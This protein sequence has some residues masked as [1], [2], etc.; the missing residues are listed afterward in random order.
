MLEIDSFLSTDFLINIV[1]FI[2]LSI[3]CANQ[4]YIINLQTKKLDTTKSKANLKETSKYEWMLHD[5]RR[6]NTISAPIWTTKFFYGIFR[7]Y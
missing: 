6:E 3:I 1:N 4:M 7:H 5:I 2:G